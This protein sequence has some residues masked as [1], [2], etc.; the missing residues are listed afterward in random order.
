MTSAKES[1]GDDLR[2]TDTLELSDLVEEQLERTEELEQR[3]TSLSSEIDD[4]TTNLGD[5]RTQDLQVEID[6]LMNEAGLGPIVGPGVTV[7]LDDADI[8]DNL[9]SGQSSDYLVHQQDVDAVINALWAGGAEA[10]T[11][12]GH[13][14]T[15][16]SVV[17]CEGPV[18]NVDGSVYSPPYEIAAIGDADAMIDAL[19][20]S[21]QV[22]TYLT[23]VVTIGLGWDV[24]ISDELTVPGIDETTGRAS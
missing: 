14:V 20:D 9:P 10:M 22:S 3:A 17:S 6:S 21:P 12:M 16:N 15:M 13:R 7:S 23:Y 18:I 2:V 4:L 19:G 1:G 24:Q 5:G 11:V 8:P